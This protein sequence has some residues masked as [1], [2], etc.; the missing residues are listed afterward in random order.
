MREKGGSRMT[1]CGE[2]MH[3]SRTSLE[4]T[5]LPPPGITAT[6]P[7]H[8]EYPDKPVKIEL[9]FP[10]GGG[11]DILARW[12]AAKLQEKASQTFVVENKVGA[13][14]NISL[15]ATAKVNG[16]I[17][18]RRGAP[19]GFDGRDGW[20]GWDT[21]RAEMPLSEVT[22]LIVDLRSLTQGVG[23]FEM[24]FD[25]FAELNGKLADQV[26]ATQRAA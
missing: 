18:T 10:A 17:G 25:H 12:Y 26:V 7:A 6:V 9:G 2:K 1:L 11:A 19:L 21:V 20:R 4:T 15:D 3:S 5:K 23:T 24:E 16:L 14:G 22:D 13:S 8:A